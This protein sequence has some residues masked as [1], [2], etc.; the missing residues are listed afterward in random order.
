MWMC[1]LVCV[2]MW[3]CEDGVQRSVLSVFLDC[4][5][6]DGLSQGL[7][8]TLQPVTGSAD[9]PMRSRDLL[10]S[11]SPSPAEIKDAAHRIY[12]GAEDA[13]LGLC[14]IDTHREKERCTNTTG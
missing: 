12:V 7:S 11:A 1:V 3:L 4:F 13:S 14:N 8:L 9:W 2:S 5:L 6:P 10:F